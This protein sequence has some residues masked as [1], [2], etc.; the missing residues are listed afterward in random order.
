MIE[1]TRIDDINRELDKLELVNGIIGTAI[2]NRNGLTIS[3]RLPR[4]IDS[5]K[6]GAM[7]ATMFEAME[8]AAATLK[9]KVLNL[10]TEFDDY[11]LIVYAL[12][13]DIIFVAYLELNIDLGIVLIEI[14][15]CTK[16]ICKILEV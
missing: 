3:S 15:E 11:Q 2:V 5:R 10:S 8:T 6:F 12:N 14:E 13:A 1:S 7:A 16:I 4:D 9:D